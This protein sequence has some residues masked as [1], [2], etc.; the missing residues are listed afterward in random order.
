MDLTLPSRDSRYGDAI[1]STPSGGPHFYYALPGSRKLKNSAGVLAP[2]IDVRAEG[3]YVVAPPSKTP[4]GSYRWSQ[5]PQH[6]MAAPQWLIESC[7][8]ERPALCHQ[9]RSMRPTED[10][11][12]S[13]AETIRDRLDRDER[14]PLGQRNH[15]LNREAFYLAQFVGKGFSAAELDAWLLAAAQRSQIPQ[16]E[17]RRTIDSALRGTPRESAAK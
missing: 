5:Y 7:R 14:A 15:T 10:I 4:A 11:P 17:A 9:R 16:S 12:P 2:G 13:V 6:L 3:G 8:I 1:V